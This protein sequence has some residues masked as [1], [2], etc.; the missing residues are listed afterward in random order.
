MDLQQLVIFF[1]QV[2]RQ[3]QHERNINMLREFPFG[4]SLSKGSCCEVILI[5][6][7]LLSGPIA[8]TSQFWYHL[9]KIKAQGG[10]AC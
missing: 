1:K 9:F 5:K 10:H 3:A 2:L 7:C 4:L 8:S 6:S